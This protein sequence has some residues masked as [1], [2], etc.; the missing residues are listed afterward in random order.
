MKIRL[1]TCIWR[2]AFLFCLTW[3]VAGRLFDFERNRGEISDG[4]CWRKRKRK[5]KGSGWRKG[6]KGGT[7]HKRESLQKNEARAP[8][9]RYLVAQHL[10]PPR[11]R[12]E[13]TGMCFTNNTW[14]FLVW[15]KAATIIKKNWLRLARNLIQ[16]QNK[17]MWMSSWID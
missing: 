4:E 17:M 10:A 16:R 5:K 11:C 8:K 2:V 7:L 1:Y 14:I 3:A 13:M 6:E 9:D 15:W 12:L